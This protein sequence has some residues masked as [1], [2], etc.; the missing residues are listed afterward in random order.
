MPKSLTVSLVVAFSA[1]AIYWW[2]T[3]GTSPAKMQEDYISVTLGAFNLAAIIA[4]FVILAK[5]ESAA[6]D[7]FGKVVRD[8]ISTVVA[9]LIINVVITVYTLPEFFSLV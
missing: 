2:T 1:L 5:H 9:A 7:A 6:P 4:F 3:N 8:N